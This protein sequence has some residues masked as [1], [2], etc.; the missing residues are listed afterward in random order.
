MSRS[1]F[2]LAAIL[3][4]AILAPQ[5][6]AETAWDRV[7]KSAAEHDRAINLNNQ[8]NILTSQGRYD[9]AIAAAK[10]AIS[11]LPNYGT[12]YNNLG[13][14]YLRKG[15]FDEAISALTNALRI[16]PGQPVTLNS[17]GKAYLLK[18]DYDAA[19]KD[20]DESIQ[21]MPSYSYAYNNRGMAYQQKGEIDRAIADF[22]EALRLKPNLA[23]ALTNR[24]NAYQAK[25][26]AE[27]AN[28]DFAQAARYTSGTSSGAP[29]P[30]PKTAEESLASL[31]P[32][33]AKGLSPAIR[34]HLILGYDYGRKGEDDRAIAEFTAAIALKQ[35]PY[36]FY[37]RAVAYIRKGDYDQAINDLTEAL[38]L[39]PFT[40]ALS[41]RA[42]V[43]LKK[44]DF[45]RAIAD[46]SAGMKLEPGNPR[47]YI[48]RA[49]AYELSGASY[50]ALDD[51]VTAVRL[52]RANVKLVH[53][54]VI[55]KVSGRFAGK[56][57]NGLIV[58]RGGAEGLLALGFKYAR[59]GRFKE[60][61]LSLDAAIKSKP[62][63]ADAYL[64]RGLALL[65]EGD[66]DRGVADL[67]EAERLEG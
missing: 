34:D 37:C 18:G 31:P 54:L 8:A 53:G 48:F 67:K 51:L 10:E 52:D 32:D 46:S 23:E 19:I 61:L 36:S 63:L 44:S 59:E 39:K 65:A 5:A 30:Q 21:L 9:E 50:R 40:W 3:S 33:L 11:I 45:A 2:H 1:A 47:A 26:D 58:T 42:F 28:A 29:V 43:Y 6:A 57:T 17:R 35:E 49:G 16:L 24:G 64:L 7:E 4:V 12:A 66:I 38:R 15:A 25:G 13:F 27:H 60:A 41:N 56:E 14:A 55:K 22:N 20:L 62:D